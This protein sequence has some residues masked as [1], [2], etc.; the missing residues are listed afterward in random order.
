M[1]T[2][3]YLR[4][5]RQVLPRHAAQWHTVAFEQDWR[6]LIMAVQP[7][8]DT[9]MQNVASTF[10]PRLD[11]VRAAPAD[12]GIVELIVRRP[13]EGDRELLDE[14]RIDEDLGL[15]G[16]RWATRDVA[17]T[18]VY[19]SAQ[20]TLISTRV[21]AIIEPDQ[22]RWALAGDQLYVDFD[23]GEANLPAKSRLAVGTAILEVSETPHTGCAKFSARFGSD[24][25]RWINSP[26]G[27]AHRMRGMNARVLRGGV[28]HR[29]DRI[30][31]A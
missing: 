2:T 11:E 29:G 12:E 20:L 7:T 4:C 6:I 8:E 21:L 16:D 19:L 23:L 31:K 1:T 14:A 15:V 13:A 24:A 30:R 3:G 17:R 27:R 26:I 9:E 25:L 5:S 18:P 10:D 28:V 22:A